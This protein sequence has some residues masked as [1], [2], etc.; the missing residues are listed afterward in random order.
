[1]SLRARIGWSI[2]S[3]IQAYY[4]GQVNGRVLAHAGTRAGPKAYPPQFIDLVR[5]VRF[6]RERRPSVLWELG[7]GWSTQFLAQALADNGSGHMYSMDAAAEW[8]ANARSM[9][10][11]WL[12]PWVEIHHSA[13]SKREVGGT[14]AVKYAWRPEAMP[15]FIYVD[16]P[17]G[18][19]E[20]PGHADLLDIEPQLAPGCFIVI[21]GRATTAEF[22]RTHFR[23]EWR[24][25]HDPG[26]LGRYFSQFNQHY[27]E[28]QR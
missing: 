16:G 13:V 7:S 17:A 12:E 3:I 8:A 10:P 22:L 4:R 25:W 24:Y 23:R 21:D 19:K 2:H 6:V 15:Q 9:L 5:L 11:P 18:A 1:M 28:L 27:L 20:C 26:P 14:C